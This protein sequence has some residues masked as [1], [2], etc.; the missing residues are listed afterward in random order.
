MVSQSNFLYGGME[1]PCLSMISDDVSGEDNFYTIVH[2]TA[3]QWFY[4]ILGV[5][6]SESGY[7]DEGLTELSTALFLGQY[8]EFNGSFSDLI[9]KA[10]KNYVLMRKAL[11]DSGNKIPAIMERNLN[12]FT[13]E[14]EYAVDGSVKKESLYALADRYALTFLEDKE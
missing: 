2:E 8:K 13:S 12:D 9:D 1:Y 6:E 14:L 7:L 5:N 3:H 4:G 11:I 10:T